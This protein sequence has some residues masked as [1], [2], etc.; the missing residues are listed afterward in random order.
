MS[1]T[2]AFIVIG[3]VVLV[4]AVVFVVKMAGLLSDR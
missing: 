4:V 1:E 3:G 2:L